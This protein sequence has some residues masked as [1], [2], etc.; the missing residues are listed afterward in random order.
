MTH[1]D[2][3]YFNYIAEREGLSVIAENDAFLTYRILGEECFIANMF[4]EPTKR[5][6]GLC[7]TLIEKLSAIAKPKG[8]TFISATIQLNDSH[9][10][11]TLIAAFGVGFELVR[12][13]QNVLI[14]N[15]KLGGS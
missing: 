5:A 12:A 9:A 4:I 7:R 8:V 6:S 3:L 11:K 1:A 14:I 2:S 10:T 15:K 13:N